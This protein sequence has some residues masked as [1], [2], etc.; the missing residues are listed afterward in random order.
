M[1]GL[2]LTHRSVSMSSTVFLQF[3]LKC[4]YQPFIFF[5]YS[6]LQQ[7]WSIIFSLYFLPK[8]CSTIALSASHS[9]PSL[10]PFPCHCDVCG[11]GKNS[12]FSCLSP[13][14]LHLWADGSHGTPLNTNL[15]VRGPPSLPSLSSPHYSTLLASRTLTFPPT[16]PLYPLVNSPSPF[17]FFPLCVSTSSP[18][19]VPLPHSFP[20]GALSMY[21]VPL[22]LLASPSSMFPL[23]HTLFPHHCFL[24]LSL[25]SIPLPFIAA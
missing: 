10:F 19:S 4:L 3:G 20:L 22:I 8:S 15:P 11:L 21:R 12:A 14:K 2:S 17:Y 7:S 6:F 5:Y 13:G 1:R 24:S 25:P 9:F 18:L 16:H 23:F